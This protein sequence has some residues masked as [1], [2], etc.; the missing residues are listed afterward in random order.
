[1]ISALP[2]SCADEHQER[3]LGALGQYLLWARTQ[4]QVMIEQTKLWLKLC[5]CMGAGRFLIHYPAC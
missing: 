2:N 5:G 4:R 3:E 1:M